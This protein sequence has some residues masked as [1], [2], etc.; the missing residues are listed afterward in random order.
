MF[1]CANSAR[2]E[3][4]DVILPA[5]AIKG[6]ATGTIVAVFIVVGSVL[7][8]SIPRIISSAIKNNT[9]EPATAKLFTSTPKKVMIPS[10]INKNASIIPSATNDALPG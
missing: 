5:P 3:R 1:S 9:N 2:R 7:K 4:I 10:P 8:S 6:K